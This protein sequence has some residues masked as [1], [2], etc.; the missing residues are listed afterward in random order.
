MYAVQAQGG[1]SL[2][3]APRRGLFLTVVAV[4][5][6]ADLASKL[7]AL[8]FLDGGR[9][10]EL[11]GSLLRLHLVHNAG[12]AFSLGDSATWVLTLVALALTGWIATLGWRATHPGWVWALALLLG[13][14]LGNLLD[15][16]IRAPGPGR[17]QVVDFIDYGGLFVGNIADIAI[18]AGAILLALLT[19][20]G[21]P[22]HPQPATAGPQ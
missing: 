13:G 2:N 5:F 1:A 16:F 20:R 4:S 3:A 19:L 10:I 7:A 6:L 18:V 9:V 11:A 12:A 15:R 8:A 17:G 22:A 21:I 14:A